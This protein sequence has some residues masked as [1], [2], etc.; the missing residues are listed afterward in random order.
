MVAAGLDDSD[1]ALNDGLKI[2]AGWVEGGKRVVPAQDIHDAVKKLRRADPSA[3]FTIQAI[4]DDP[5]AT[6]ADVALRWIDLYDGDNP[7]VRVQPREPA[8]WQQMD[9]EVTQAATTLEERGWHSVLIRGSMRQATFFRVGIA[10]PAVR[11]H[12]LRYRQGRQLW[13]T[14]APKA[15]IDP[16]QT[17]TTQLD[18]GKDLAVAVG[19]TLDPTDEVALY[20][21]TAAIPTNHLITVTPAT[22]PD[23]QS[24]PTAG[25]AVSYA[26]QVRNLV[27]A[28][29]TPESGVERIHL[30]LAG[31]G[32]LA[33]LLGHRW[34]RTRETI[35][36]EHLGV[37][38]G[39]T[40]AFTIGA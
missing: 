14:D 3:I 7:R 29:L 24:V 12:T 9:H 35:V 34:N 32:G 11:Q 38:R 2:V 37:G 40:P 21:R 25:H 33:L 28:H 18:L 27:R 15:A 39:Y 13:S 22:G 31:P 17:T 5:H 8:A 23:D 10:L 30:F 19:V 6:D 1:D 26:E 36:Y 20:L 16:P 4:D